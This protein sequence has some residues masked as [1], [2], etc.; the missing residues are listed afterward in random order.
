MDFKFEYYELQF[1]EN[2]SVGYGDY[3]D[4]SHLELEKKNYIFTIGS[5]PI[6]VFVYDFFTDN[7]INEEL[8]RVISIGGRIYNNRGDISGKIDLKKL[9]KNYHSSID[10][11]TQY[12]ESG[13]RVKTNEKVKFQFCNNLRYRILNKHKPY[14]AE[15]K[16]KYDNAF[17]EIVKK[18]NTLFYHIFDVDKRKAIFGN[19]NEMVINHGFRSAIHKDRNNL[20][21]A[22][23]LIVIDKTQEHLKHSNLNLPDF[24]I[25]I[26]L[27]C[28][29]SVL[30]MNLKDIRH[31]NDFIID[32]LQQN[33]IS[34]VM[35]N[36]KTAI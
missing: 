11:N 1:Q 29:K 26:P 33:K 24:N 22:S 32:E 23:C 6:G 7:E 4:L 9:S 25:S 36:K 8:I 18:T 17:K 35:Y 19:W 3:I 13:C 14:Y 12:N 20:D 31:S 30:I 10:E 16:E 28:N 5:I 15:R 21:E 34:L 27:K 2:K